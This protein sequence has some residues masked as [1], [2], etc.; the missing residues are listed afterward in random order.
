MEFKI[1]PRNSSLPTTGVDTAYLKENHWND[2]SFITAFNLS[3]HDKEGN[4]HVIGNLRI[5][6]VD[7]YEEESTS[8]RLGTAF[9]GTLP[10]DF[11][12]LGMNSEF[13]D[14]LYLLDENLKKEILISIRDVSFDH[15][16]LEKA[17]DQRVFSISLL[18]DTSLATIKGKYSRLIK[19]LSELTPFDFALVLSNENHGDRNIEFNV[20]VESTPSTSVHAIIGKNGTGKTTLLNGLLEGIIGISPER[21]K[22]IDLNSDLNSMIEDNYFSNIHSV[23]FSAFDD[24]MPPPD[25]PFQSYGTCYYYTGLK[26]LDPDGGELKSL[27]E[28]RMEMCSSLF[29]CFHDLK[30]KKLKRF[31]HAVNILSSDQNIKSL[32]LEQYFDEYIALKK[33]HYTAKAD[34]HKP[35]IPE[36]E[37][38][39]ICAEIFQEKLPQ[40]SSGH[41]IVLLTTFKLISTVDERSLILI[42]EPESH[43]HPPLLSAFIRM[44]SWLLNQVNGVSIIATHSPVVLQ[45]IPKKCVWKVMRSETEVEFC[46]PNIETFGE[47]VG[48]LTKEI[49]GLEVDKSG[50]IT[51]LKDL[52]HKGGSFEYIYKNILKRQI[53]GEGLI[54]LRTLVDIRDRASNK[55]D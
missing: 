33:E 45:E 43:L 28:L 55:Y 38:G 9:D 44:L 25:Q 6:F 31:L 32:N 27:K 26:D 40:M 4:Y 47:N 35:S 15:I 16:I 29:N 13:Y 21:P 41:T 30:N 18:R 14:K 7:Q 19:G 50:F 52:V 5:G 42:D 12:S 10:E 48:V 3:L 17:R 53:G 11:F 24:F 36:Y 51:V 49:F 39:N 54:L 2:N 46:R 20:E 22:I 23:S 37:F 1:I 8:D 34:E